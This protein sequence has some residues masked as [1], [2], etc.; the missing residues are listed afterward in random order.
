MA[1]LKV[2]SYMW[3]TSLHTLLVDKMKMNSFIVDCLSDIR[4][5]TTCPQ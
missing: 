5:Y 1:G 2:T 3:H 4:T